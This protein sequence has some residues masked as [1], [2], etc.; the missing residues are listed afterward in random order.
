M[1]NKSS[2]AMVYFKFLPKK[3]PLEK[4]KLIVPFLNSLPEMEKCRLGYSWKKPFP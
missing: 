3:I 1:K 4:A 2:V